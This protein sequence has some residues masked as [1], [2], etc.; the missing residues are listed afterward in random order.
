MAPRVAL[1]TPSATSCTR[2]CVVIVGAGFLG[3]DGERRR[4]RGGRGGSDGGPEGGPAVDPGGVEGGFP[5]CP[6][7]GSKAIGLGDTWRL[8]CSSCCLF[9]G[10]V[11][12]AGGLCR[13]SVGLGFRPSGL[14]S[15]GSEWADGALVLVY[16]TGL[17]HAGGAAGTG[18]VVGSGIRVAMHWISA[19]A[20]RSWFSRVDTRF[21][22]AAAHNSTL[23]W[24]LARC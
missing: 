22:C 8:S 10:V 2:S 4:R 5:P 9:S 11:G 14:P 21:W 13:R 19:L 3:G 7:A 15:V 17:L 18:G 24:K 1:A 16:L 23:P 12:T 20:S 6:A